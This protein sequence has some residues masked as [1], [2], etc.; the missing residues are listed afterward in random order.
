MK[1][2]LGMKKLIAL[3]IILLVM[4][5]ALYLYIN[6]RSGSRPSKPWLPPSELWSWSIEG[7]YLVVTYSGSEVA[8]FPMDKVMS[9]EVLDYT[10]RPPDSD[11]VCH[12][13][14]DGLHKL[15]VYCF[16]QECKCGG[17]VLD[18][19]IGDI[20]WRFSG[21][22]ITTLNGTLHIMD[23]DNVTRG[24]WVHMEDFSASDPAIQPY[25]KWLTSMLSN[26]WSF[27][28]TEVEKS[29]QWT[30]W[31]HDNATGL[32][33]YVFDAA[34]RASPILYREPRLAR[35]GVV[36]LPFGGALVVTALLCD[37]GAH[38]VIHG[39]I[40]N[41]TA[42]REL[43][44][45]W[46]T[47]NAGL[48][49]Y[50]P[51]IIPVDANETNIH[52]MWYIKETVGLLTY[53]LEKLVGETGTWPRTIGT[54]ELYN[55]TGWAYWRIGIGTGDTYIL[56][57]DGVIPI[58]KVV[59]LLEMPVVANQRTLA[60]MINE[61]LF[62]SFVGHPAFALAF[63]FA[64]PPG[65]DPVWLY[66]NIV[67][68][69]TR[70]VVLTDVVYGGRVWESLGPYGIRK[71]GR[72]VCDTYATSTAL[73]AAD[74]MGGYSAYVAVNTPMLSWPIHAVSI[75]VLGDGHGYIDADKDGVPDSIVIADTANLAAD[76]IQKN[77][78]YIGFKYPF[79]VASM[80]YRS[81]YD[82]PSMG[83]YLGDEWW[84]GEVA[85]REW[86]ADP[87]AKY[88]I[89]IYDAVFRLPKWLLAPW[90][91]FTLN[92]SGFWNMFRGTDEWIDKFACL[93]ELYE[94][95][96]QYVNATGAPNML[97]RPPSLDLIPNVTV[98]DYF[99]VPPVK[100]P[101]PRYSCI[102]WNE[103][104][105][106]VLSGIRLN[107]VKGPVAQPF[108]WVAWYEEALRNRSAQGQRQTWTPTPPTPPQ[109]E[110]KVVYNVTVE[111]EPFFVEA[112]TSYGNVTLLGGYRGSAAAPNGANITVVPKLVGFDWN[113]EKTERGLNITAIWVTFF[114]DVYV[115]G[116]QRVW[117]A[118][119]GVDDRFFVLRTSEGVAYNITLRFNPV[120]PPRLNTTIT[121]APR[122]A[123]RVGGM[124]VVFGKV[125]SHYGYVEAEFRILGITP[126]TYTI[127]PK[128]V[129]SWDAWAAMSGD[130][131]VPAIYV[132]F[133]AKAA[134]GADK[135][136]LV[137]EPLG[138]LIEI[139]LSP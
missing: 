49:V 2:G 108:D 25:L 4:G 43:L 6:Y 51:M 136:R 61:M 56:S 111:L 8:R 86:L 95:A 13:T 127:V 93:R 23:G 76:Y 3:I 85:K 22:S 71:E 139:P 138:L 7:D 105:G 18:V 125:E 137:I 75:L 123:E 77:M 47:M 102:N 103:I 10:Y 1:W 118:I 74:A 84:F 126:W 52:K 30:K 33:Y 91:D 116:S 9:T 98:A 12:V 132:W 122:K 57:A 69:F 24:L 19:K 42:W 81:V 73:F 130:D 78:F 28:Y 29:T 83:S 16:N 115:N 94:Y 90:I 134:E 32:D 87:Y 113:K 97:I 40:V 35:V 38:I 124:I 54:F 80:A 109:Q 36:K 135:V 70:T 5:A 106:L 55:L 58:R 26:K 131:P 50:N 34:F 66:R 44:V 15:Y 39:T 120:P 96:E 129:E 20:A 27:S 112:E 17:Y 68:D 63:R 62:W 41:A 107:G 110:Q 45:R 37:D 21:P 133:G 92:L 100:I 101:L 60:T 53:S 14:K 104:R 128:G 67:L 65:A 114:M 99:Y 64:Y 89:G 121:A 117:D 82:D 31:F 46:E 119:V 79:Y 59:V 88:Y 48:Q 11:A 72:G